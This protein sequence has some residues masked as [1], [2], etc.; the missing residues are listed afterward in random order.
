MLI[1]SARD[2]NYII[3]IF[4]KCI[5]PL[6]KMRRLVFSWQRQ[7]SKTTGGFFTVNRKQNVLPSFH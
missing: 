7:P 4:F 6:A 3:I 2:F 1:T 5:I